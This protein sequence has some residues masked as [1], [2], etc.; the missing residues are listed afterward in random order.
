MY[1]LNFSGKY[2]KLKWKKGKLM[3]LQLLMN[4]PEY[5]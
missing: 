1:F 2:V 5:A 4:M 3:L